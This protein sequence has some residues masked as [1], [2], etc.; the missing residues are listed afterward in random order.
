MLSIPY[1]SSIVLVVSELLVLPYKPRLSALLTQCALNH[2]WKV[3]KKNQNQTRQ[4][5]LYKVVKTD[6]FSPLI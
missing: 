6:G 5:S 4:G 3:C 1:I 2:N